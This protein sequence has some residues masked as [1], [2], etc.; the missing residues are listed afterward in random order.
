MDRNGVTGYPTDVTN[1]QWARLMPLLRPAVARRGRGRPPTVDLRRV[2]DALFDMNRTGCQGR[3]LPREFPA[4]GAVR[5]YFDTWERDGTWE[6]VNDVLRRQVR[7][8]AG[9]HPDPSAASSDRQRVQTSEA[10]GICGFDGGNTDS[11][12]QAPYRGR[13]AGPAATGVGA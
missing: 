9:R 5:Y 2:V 1:E 8:A 6:R 11:G 7:V 10:G 13:H 4:W 3:S 12:P